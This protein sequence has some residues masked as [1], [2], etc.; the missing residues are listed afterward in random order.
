M[1]KVLC[2]ALQSGGG[3]SLRL[4]YLPHISSFCLILICLQGTVYVLLSRRLERCDRVIQ[5]ESDGSIG[6]NVQYV[7][8]KIT[9]VKCAL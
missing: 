4:I 2:H 7:T 6:G 5:N 8:M 3:G 1:K 9:F